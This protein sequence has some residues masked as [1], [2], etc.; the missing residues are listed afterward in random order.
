M[1]DFIYCLN[2]STI[3][4]TP[5][6]EKIRIAGEAGYQA[7]EPWNDEINEYLQQGGTIAEL[8][9]ALA[10]AGLKVVSVIA[11]HSWVTTEGDEYAKVLDECRRRM[12]QAAQLG[13]PYIVASPPQE[14][15]DLGRATERFVELMALGKSHGRDPLDGVPRLRRRHQERRHRLGDRLGL[16]RSAGDGRRRRLPHDPRR[17]LGRRPACCSRAIAWPTSTSTTSPPTPTL[18]P[19]PTTTASWSARGSPTCRG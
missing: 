7:I 2:T 10:D 16:R 8:K 13:S 3:R 4:P 14:V 18:A 11:L 6:L 17:R 5:L 19:R 9:K 15:V 1:S 12:D